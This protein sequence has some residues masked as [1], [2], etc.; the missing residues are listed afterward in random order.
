ML[1]QVNLFPAW[2]TKAEATYNTIQPDGDGT[3]TATQTTCG[4]AGNF[5]C[6]NDGVATSSTPSTAGDYLTFLAADQ[7]YYT[8]TSLA[9]VDT[10]SAI[11]VPVYHLDSATNMNIL[12]SLWDSTETIQY[13]VEIILP[14][15]ATSQ[16]DT[17]AIT[18][19]SLTQAQLDGV[20]VRSSCVRSGGKP[21]TCNAYAMFGAVTY[22]ETIDVTVAGLGTQ[23]DL[24]V[25][26]TTALVGGSFSIVEN[27]SSRS[28]TSITITENGTVDALTDLDNIE[29]YYDLDITSPYICDGESYSPS[30]IKFGAT[31]TTGFSAANGTSTFTGAAT[32]ST[33]QTMCVYVVLDV[34]STATFGQTL[35]IEISDPTTDVVGSGSPIISP[36]T[37]ILLPGTTT[38]LQ[39]VLTQEN[40]HWRNDDGTE[41]SATSATGGTEN[42]AYATMPKDVTKRLR[43]AVSNSGNA[44]APAA[45]FRLEYA[46]KVTTCNVAVGW[47]DVEAV[48]GD[49]DM[50][51]TLNLNNGDNTTNVIVA[52]GGVSN[53]NT[54]LVT[55][56][57][58]RDT[59]S[60]T[61]SLTLTVTD[62]VAIEYSVK[63]SA[64][65]A[66]GNT[67]CFRVSDVGTSIDSY[68]TYPEATIA[69][70]VLVEGLGIQTVN[71]GIPSTYQYAGGV[72]S[73]TDATA[74]AGTVTSITITA[75]GTVDAQNDISNIKLRYDLDITNPY[76]CDDVSYAITDPQYGA[77]ST[78]F[79]G[80]NQAVYTGSVTNSTTQTVCLYAEYDV[81][82][83]ATD[84]E[85]LDLSIA[86]PSTEVVI[87]GSSVAPSSPVAIA[88]ITTFT[89]PLVTQADYHWRQNDGTEVTASSD[90]GG[91]ENTPL[92]DM[93]K[94]STHRL[95]F[96]VSNTGLANADEA[97][98]RLEWAQKIST[99]AAVAS[100][101]PFDTAMD[102]WDM[103]PTGNLI[104]GSDTTDVLEA[105]GG[106]TDSAG[107][108]LINNNGVNDTTDLTASS[109]LLVDNYL[110]LE[111]A[112]VASSTA[113]QGAT[114]CFRVTANG[115]AL[116]NYVN[117]PEATIKLNTDFK[118]QRGVSTVVG[119]SITLTAGTEYEAPAS[120]S[121]AFIRIT[122][123]QLTGAGPNTG[124]SANNADD[125]TVY[126]L[127]PSNIVT[128]ITFQRGV[129]AVGNSRVSWE[130]IE[131]TGAAGG[132]NEMI[133]RLQEAIPYV[134]VN[135]AVSGA[136]TGAIVTDA[137]VAVFITGQHNQDAGRNAFHEGL[138]TAAWNAVNN[139]VDLTRGAAG[140]VSDV[141][142][143]LV[144]FTG[145]NWKIQR[146]EH[147]YT[148][149]GSVETA[150]ITA[151]NSL[152]KT[153][154]HVQKR[155]AQANHADF[156]HEVWLSGI[157]QVSFSLDGLAI[158]P[159]SHTSV[160]WVI[161]N[162]QSQG[163]IMDVT[164]SN[165]AFT[166]AGAGPE[167]NNISIGKTIDDLT[168][169]S[170]FVNNRGDEAQRSWP[171]PILGAQIISSTQYELWRSDTSSNINY[172][173][174]VVE[175][176][177]AARKLEQNDYRLYVD[178]NAL[179]PTDPWPAGGVN[180]GENAE[181][182]ANDAPMALGDTVRIRMTLS[183]LAAAMPAGLDS[184]KLQQAK[185]ITTCSAISTWFDVGEIGSTTAPWRGVDN[186]PVDGT[187]LSG[188]P[189]TGGDL[190]ITLGSV[191]GTYEEQNNTATNP[192]AAF[193]GDEVEYDWVLQHNGADDKSSYCF[194]MVE[195]DGTLLDL[196]NSY[197]VL[198]TVGYDPQLTNWRWY[199]DETSLTPLVDLAIENV[200]PIDI[201]NQ[202]AIKLRLVLRESSGAV[203]TNVKFALQFS[204]YSDFSQAVNTLIATSTCV[205][206]SLWCYYDGSGVDNTVVSGVVISDVGTCVAGVGVGCGTHNEGTSTINATV[207]QAAY[208]S[209]E[210]E[211][212][213]LHAGARANAV[214]YFRLYDLVNNEVVL[215][216]SGSSYP[217]LV[218]KGAQLVSTLSG[219]TSGTAVAG[220][221]SD[222]ATTPSSIGYGSLPF[223]TSYEAVQRLSINTNA[224]EG[225]QMLMYATQQLTNSYGDVIPAIT[226]TNAAPA[227]WLT[228]CTGVTTGCVGYHTT[229]GT[230]AGDPAQSVRF[231]PT[232]SYAALDTSPQE[233]MYSSIPTSD[234]H[235]II[236]RILVTEEQVYGEYQAN[237][238]YVSIPIF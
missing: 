6:L 74:G 26:T 75:A 80:S 27:T 58:V 194:K 19:P 159:A 174:E 12:V 155:T 125:V 101:T 129:G 64:T 35:E 114:Y 122:N 228:A 135:T 210:Y 236:Y 2:N 144:E 199:D 149:A 45:Q 133:V 167:T 137:Q 65:V 43:M 15:R 231:G 220:I 229:D 141:S 107:T 152:S 219:V 78:N 29:L 187:V 207:D 209:T 91:V 77:T 93:S 218:T 145:G 202:N 48:G 158:A 234:V 172:R 16:W 33:T 62:Y 225:Y 169:A 191:A 193:P 96:G 46:P 227:G 47:T 175:W 49:F 110:D 117:Y 216:S 223:N 170:L 88:G 163:T 157:G 55:N 130:I 222:V 25:G 104:E 76:T 9:S 86:D 98:Y 11:D 53:A 192:Y 102:E 118:I 132:E 57:A 89:A 73:L 128:N 203:G 171:E 235:D 237:I 147:T 8:M 28:I 195:A 41:A 184:F 108:F 54:F 232:D 217:S 111:Y 177:T 178:N 7:D 109:T 50:S 146:A 162:T 105:D 189:P 156:G 176:P 205:E 36:A 186:T 21:G 52:D 150:A 51:D 204:E 84:G 1:P 180:L 79:N 179:L 200:A 100:W 127:N 196:N 4:G 82:A 238:V 206:D 208:A 23:Q 71:V 140:V 138:S 92:S 17:A 183:V 134:S 168:I 24:E 224:T 94:S 34:L 213:I 139:Q 201:L 113:V 87:S 99:C 90:T 67:Y 20:R 131:Y 212:T 116:D 40:Y 143:A 13:G 123:T 44:T 119:D 126:V 165:G 5:D 112:I 151:V 173:T 230:L 68:V 153:F 72:F 22:I 106:V 95:R 38:L 226:S 85:T 61:G 66:D 233:V 120:A 148:N 37:A 215:L 185:R 164:R 70:D 142:Y 166:S 161:E 198:R 136:V 83:G 115:T 221:V 124:N 32:I 214:Y 211:F 160:I 103:S 69:A 81:E 60:Q 181:M 63:A 188:D 197:P 56:A 39:S 3:I 31:D 30:S 14:T 10:V 182:T 190:L 42:T 97:R 121:S 18:V 59:T 154:V